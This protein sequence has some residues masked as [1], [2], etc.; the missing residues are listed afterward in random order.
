M[1]FFVAATEAPKPKSKES[2][3]I[4]YLY[5]L[6]LLVMALCQLFTFDDFI[7]LIESF[8]LPISDSLA[9]LLTSVII[10]S[11]IFAIPFLIRMRLSP[12]MRIICMILGWL[13]PLIWV[14][15]SLW[16]NLTVNNISNIGFLGGL[17]DLTPGLWTIFLSISLGIMSVWASW[18]MWPINNTLSSKR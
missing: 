4:A 9:Y 11:E 6:L 1:S 5:A 15:L 3:Q 12:L 2:A 13:V 17:I 18:G 10:V 14:I 16:V 7:I 8:W